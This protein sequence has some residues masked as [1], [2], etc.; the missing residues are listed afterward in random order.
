MPGPDKEVQ[1][2][3]PARDRAVELATRKPK[4]SFYLRQWICE[5]GLQAT[6]GSHRSDEMTKFLTEQVE[7]MESYK[8]TCSDRKLEED[9]V[10]VEQ[11]ALE[12]F[13]RADRADRGGKATEKTAVTFHAASIFISC[14]ETFAPLEEEMTKKARYCLWRAFEIRKALAEGR[15]PI[16]PPTLHPRP[17]S[18]AFTGTAA[19]SSSSPPPTTTTRH[20]D[21]GNIKD[22]HDEGEEDPFGSALMPSHLVPS[23][24]AG[25]R[26]PSSAPTAIS[27]EFEANVVATGDEHPRRGSEF[28][29]V[30]RGETGPPAPPPFP[31][32]PPAGPVFPDPA[33]QVT[34]P[35]TKNNNNQ[36][37]P[38]ITHAGVPKAR[39]STPGSSRPSSASRAGM[40]EARKAT[41]QALSALDF[42]DIHTAKELLRKALAALG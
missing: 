40:N 15:A 41:K 10:E 24:A 35:S 11:F 1:A 16:P 39:G 2:L 8:Q 37:H 19:P 32:P 13:D 42:D 38:M 31:P 6:G 12:V 18:S 25:L 28:A 5:Q 33:K 26:A 34:P 30:A 20:A 3:R 21:D 9:V 17:T 22:I 36:S 29:P 14:L 4:V 23:P 7:W 27:A